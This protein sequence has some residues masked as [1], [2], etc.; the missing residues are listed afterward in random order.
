M[1]T[2]RFKLLWLFL[3]YSFQIH[4]NPWANV[5]GPA[6]GPT[7]V[8]GD[9]SAGCISGART[10]PPEGEGYVVMHL[11]RDRYYGHPSL[12]SAIK[13]LGQRAAAGLGIM[14]VGDLGMARGGPMPFGHR[15]HQTGLDADVWFDLSPGLH[16]GANRDR[17]NVSA[18]S[19]LSKVGDG[20]DYRLWSDS[21]AQM[22]K[23]AAMQPAVDRIFVNARIKQEL[24]RSSRGDREWLRKI[25]PWYR[26]EDHFHI[27]LACPPDSPSCVRQE[28]VPPGDGC[29]ALG[30]WLKK[31]PDVPATKPPPPPKPRMP[32]E[33]RELLSRY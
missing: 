22:L 9:T 32:A 26:H 28:P 11:E 7:R 4:A 33:C 31:T 3:L 5:P 2:Q 24:C 29:E 16:L 12:I 15:S 8:I 6:P 10:L 19:L 13:A 30:W 17:S 18:Y 20:V 14:H 1:K 25:R 23:A 21:H 27:R